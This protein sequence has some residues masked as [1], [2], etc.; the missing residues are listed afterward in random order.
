[1]GFLI[2]LGVIAVG[3]F[4]WQVIDPRGAWRATESWKFRNPDANEPSDTA[5]AMARVGGVVGIVGLA[6]AG[7]MMYGATRSA[8]DPSDGRPA[9]P[10]YSVPTYSPPTYRSFDLGPGTVVGYRYPSELTVELVV[11]DADSQPRIVCSTDVDVYEHTNAV[12]VR[13]ARSL[14]DFRGR[15]EP[16][17]DDCTE[18]SPTTVTR[19][20][21]HPIGDR[22]ILTAAPVVDAASVGLR[23]GP[24]VRPTPLVEVPAPG[25]V[26]PQHPVRIDPSW[27]PVPLLAA[28]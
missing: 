8:D 13:V 5:F 21:A 28:E 2:V 23:P 22:P 20:L 9:R 12:V 25:V 3:L 10:A 1:M 19:A 18:S 27:R 15:T 24:R 11:L 26:Q 4:L 6:V 17:P 7:A 14:A 16:D